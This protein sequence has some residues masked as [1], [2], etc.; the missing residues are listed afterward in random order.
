VTTTQGYSLFYILGGYS[1]DHW[2]NQIRLIFEKHGL[3]SFIVHPDYI[4][5]KR[6]QGIYKELLA[7]LV[8]LRAEDDIWIA[9][10]RE[11]DEWWRARS[12]M[13][14]FSAGGTWRIKSPQQERARVAY[15]RIEED[16]F[17]YRV[18]DHPSKP[19]RII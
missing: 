14:L 12:Q 4:V 8:K 3:A 10:P 16:R 17:V 11:I 1:I 9:L 6:Q 5:E 7:Y 2:K 13:Q 15:A 19:R 18:G